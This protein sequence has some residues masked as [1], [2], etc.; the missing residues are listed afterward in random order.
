MRTLH[1]IILSILLAALAGCTCNISCNTM[2]GSSCVSAAQSDPLNDHDVKLILEQAEAAAKAQP[3]LVR[4]DSAGAKQMTRMHIIVMNRNGS[5]VGRRSMPDAW[6]GSLSIASAKAYTAM[7][8]SS[9]ENALTT[10]SIGALSQPGGPLWNI[11]NSNNGFG[12]PGLIEFPGGI[13]LY[14]NGALVGGIGVSGDGVEEDENVA[15]AGAKSFDAPAALRVD[16]VTGNAV[17]FVK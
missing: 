2:G 14:K 16:T 8:F 6:H 13:P 12:Q 5:V 15:E 1:I 3:S 17:P 4:V 9:D 10:R 11:G 7:A